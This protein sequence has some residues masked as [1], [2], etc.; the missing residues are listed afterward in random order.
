[1]AVE[2]SNTAVTEN[3]KLGEAR[4]KDF[5]ANLAATADVPAE[6]QTSSH[7]LLPSTIEAYARGKVLTDA[8]AANALDRIR[9]GEDED[10]VLDDVRAGRYV[11][12]PAY[13]REPAGIAHPLAEQP[14]APVPEEAPRPEDVD[15]NVPSGDEPTAHVVDD[16]S[17]V[18][19]ETPEVEPSE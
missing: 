4:R 12:R 18:Q 17:V 10:Q 8:E 2:A 1:M 3:D 6:E 5:E 11:Y 15:P 9:A 14:V 16:E 19:P 7:A 13:V